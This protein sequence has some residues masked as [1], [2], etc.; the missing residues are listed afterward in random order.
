MDD[1]RIDFSRLDPTADSER[2]EGLVDSIVEAAAPELA[3]RRAQASVVGQ[4]GL[5]WRPLLAAAAIAGIIS[6]GALLSYDTPSPTTDTEM[7]IAEAIGVPVQI[8]E[9][10]RSEGVPTTEELLFGLE[11]DS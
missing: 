2:F 8:A 6:I 11:E 7:G 4:V 10:V 3:R 9:W 5:W 1:E